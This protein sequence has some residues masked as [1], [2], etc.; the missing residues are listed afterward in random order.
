MKHAKTTSQGS[1]RQEYDWL[2]DPFNEDKQAEDMEMMK[3]S[4]SAKLALGCLVL[5]V[6]FVVLVFVLAFVMFGFAGAID[7][8]MV[9]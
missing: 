5:I 9:S 2:D 4:G 6:L 3:T 7:P 1:K 8:S